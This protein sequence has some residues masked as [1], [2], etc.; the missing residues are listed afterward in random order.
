ML[1]DAIATKKE[2]LAKAHYENP[3]E[4]QRARLLIN[5]EEVK[6]GTVE[7]MK[8]AFRL[9]TGI[10]QK[11]NIA[12]QQWQKQVLSDKPASFITIMSRAVRTL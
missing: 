12:V 8:E 4:L 1:A 2:F 7:Q 3:D 5:G 10:N 6:R 11:A 9:Q